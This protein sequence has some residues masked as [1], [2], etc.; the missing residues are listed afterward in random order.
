MFQFRSLDTG[1]SHPIPLI[2]VVYWSQWIKEQGRNT[3]LTLSIAEEDL[4]KKRL[5]V[6]YQLE[7]KVGVAGHGA[8]S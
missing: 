8:N 2:W 5:F 3:V 4:L 7:L 6:G 1:Y